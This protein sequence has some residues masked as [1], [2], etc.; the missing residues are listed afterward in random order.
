MNI[1][2]EDEKERHMKNR[3]K[4]RFMKDILLLLSDHRMY[5]NEKNYTLRCLE[6]LYEMGYYRDIESYF[7]ENKQ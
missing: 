2:V 5:I 3:E 4:Y 6:N 7:K 1:V